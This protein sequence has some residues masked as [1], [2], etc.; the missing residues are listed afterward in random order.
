MVAVG[1]GLLVLLNNTAALNAQV[2]TKESWRCDWTDCGTPSPSPPVNVPPSPNV[3]SDSGT[4]QS[5]PL[6]AVKE[7]SAAELEQ[8]ATECRGSFDQDF[9]NCQ[10]KCLKPKCNVPDPEA[11]P[12]VDKEQEEILCLQDES[13]GCQEDCKS[14]NESTRASRCRLDCLQRRCPRAPAAL[15]G[16]E[17][18]SP[19][20]IKCDR[21]KQEHQRDCRDICAVSAGALSTSPF[22]G[23]GAFG[24]IKLC[25]QTTCS[26]SC[27]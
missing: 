14:V 4:I 18:A 20:T 22:A 11:S 9:F 6:P 23:A 21:C 12:T 3:W 5:N 13:P 10:H 2:P 7:C 19:G 27:M 17:A 15:R 25:L 16:K 1:F 8:C 26:D 24:C